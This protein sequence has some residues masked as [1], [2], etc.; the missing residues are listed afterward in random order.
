MAEKTV[1]MSENQEVTTQPE[2]TQMRERYV[3]PLL[4]PP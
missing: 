4:A 3:T 1:A 2:G